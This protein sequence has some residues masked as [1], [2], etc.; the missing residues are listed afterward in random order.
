MANQEQ[1]ELLSVQITKE[2]RKHF[3]QRAHDRGYPSV[4]EYLVALAL[5]DLDD[6]DSDDEIDPEESFRRGWH[7]AMTGKTRPIEE[8][9]GELDSE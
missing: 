1:L 9:W 2:Q 6:E 3:E 7:D 4:G 5:D 8:I